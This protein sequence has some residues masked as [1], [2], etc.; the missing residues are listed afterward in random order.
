MDLNPLNSFCPHQGLVSR[1]LADVRD[2]WACIRGPRLALCAGSGAL[3]YTRG[4][5]PLPPEEL[6]QRSG[7]TAQGP[8]RQPCSPADLLTG[9]ASLA[10]QTHNSGNAGCS[11]WD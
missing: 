7:V 5:R 4:G 11:W 3:G 1:Q 2:S 10:P 9:A 8:S 6:R